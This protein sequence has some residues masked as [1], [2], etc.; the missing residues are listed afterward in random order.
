M[1]VVYTFC[2]S[3]SRVQGTTIERVVYGKVDSGY[4]SINGKVICN[5]RNKELKSLEVD[6]SKTS[7]CYKPCSGI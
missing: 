5:K 4:N 3:S 7:A 6:Y 1:K 2:D